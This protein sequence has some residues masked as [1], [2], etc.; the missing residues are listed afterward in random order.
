MDALIVERRER[1][2]RSHWGRFPVNPSKFNLR[3]H[4]PRSWFERGSVQRRLALARGETQRW[5]EAAAVASQLP[6]AELLAWYRASQTLVAV[7]LDRFRADDHPSG[8]WDIE[9]EV[10]E[11]YYAV[12]WVETG[13]EPEVYIRDAIELVVWC[14]HANTSS[15]YEGIPKQHGTLV[16]SLLTEI[17]AEVRRHGMVD[18]E[19]LVLDEW[20]TFAAAHDR[21]DEWVPL[22]HAIGSSDVFATQFLAEVAEHVD[23]DLAL[24]VFAASNRPGPQQDRVIDA[25]VSMFNRAPPPLRLPV[26]S[27]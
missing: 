3:L 21:C 2:L 18:K 12:P 7:L 24:Q 20:A 5:R 9:E 23:A 10:F 25:C 14:V 13:I 19:L 8:P 6:P 27:I 4:F 22:A 16:E 17:L 26:R 11:G 15:F 1:A